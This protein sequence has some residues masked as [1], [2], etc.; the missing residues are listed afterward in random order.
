V[1]TCSTLTN[2]R[3]NT[4]TQ[5]FTYD[6]LN[7]VITGQSQASSGSNCWGQGIPTDGTGYDRW[8][9]LLKVNSTKCSTPALNVA[10]DGLN[11]L[12][13]FSY[14]A[15]GNMLGDG[16]YTYSYNAEGLQTST[17]ASSQRYTY[18]GD[19]RR[20]KKSNGTTF[21][22]SSVAGALLVETDASGNVL[23]QYIYLGGR[24]VARK[25]GPGNVF[26]YFEEPAGR[27]RTVTNA[28]ESRQGAVL[29]SALCDCEE[30]YSRR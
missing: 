30:D 25:D 16:L 11:H 2:N 26:Y 1:A 15:A 8:G 6:A 17:S 13:G 5:T 23:S 9:N 22:F 20:V 3:D 7:R 4:R 27:T 10:T 19:G 29:R 28:S 14:D 12:S 18:D 21:W 24:R